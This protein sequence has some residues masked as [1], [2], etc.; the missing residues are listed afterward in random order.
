MVNTPE[1]FGYVF[2][3]KLQELVI[4]RFDQNEDVTAKFLNE[5]EFEKVVA[6]HLAKAVYDQIRREGAEEAA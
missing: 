6:E 2:K 1:N 4:E 3:E 5:E